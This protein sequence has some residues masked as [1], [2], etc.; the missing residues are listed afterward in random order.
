MSNDTLFDQLVSSAEAVPG[1]RWVLGGNA[2]AMAR[3]FAMEG[4]DV[5]LG[6]RVAQN[7]IDALP[8]TVKGYYLII[9]FC[10]SLQDN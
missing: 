3:R 7:V 2:P 1:H 10:I 4:L 5:L 6:A 9:Y 8:D